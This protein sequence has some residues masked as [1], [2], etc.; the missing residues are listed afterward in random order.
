MNAHTYLTQVIP[1]LQTDRPD[2]DAQILLAHVLDCPRSRLI[3][4]LHAPLTPPQIESANHTF[5]RLRTGEPLPYILGHWEFFGLDFDITN[6]VLIPRPETEL[7][8][9]KAIDWLKASPERKTVA[10]VGTGSGLIATCIAMN[11]PDARILATDISHA[12]L[13]IAK[14][15]AEK[16]HVHHNIEFVECDLL[17]QSSIVNRQSKI[18]LICANLPY[19]PTQ[20]LKGLPIFRREPTI[21]LD[22]GE[23]GLTIIRRLLDLAPARLAPGG[24]ILLEI[25]ATQGSKARAL[26]VEKF[27]QASIA[28][29]QDL[30]GHDRLLEISFDED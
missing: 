13:K 8:V 25:E 10:D 22:G 16:F 26:A 18:D 2:M 11:V 23:D 9:E 12:A 7:L 19:I 3:A 15:N 20:T 24:R 29:H 5:A 21:A 27:P 6:D 28:L 17:P 30:A 1:T 14:H 4:N